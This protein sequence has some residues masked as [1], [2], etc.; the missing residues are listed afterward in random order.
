MT[1]PKP[2]FRLSPWSEFTPT[3]QRQVAL[4]SP[5]GRGQA[6]VEIDVLA[7]MALNLTMDKLVTIYHV[8][9]PVLQK[10]ERR[11][12][13]DQRGMQV[14]VRTIRGEL[15]PNEHHPDFPNMVPPFTPVDHED[16]YREARASFEDRLGKTD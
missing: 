6:Q 7:A 13:F 14:P 11:L 12:R 16:D 8:Q 1:G 15:G 3:W 9:F 2:D 5:F 10:H 4:R